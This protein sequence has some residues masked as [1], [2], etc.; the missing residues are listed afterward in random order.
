MGDECGEAVGEETEMGGDCVKVPFRRAKGISPSWACQVPTPPPNPQGTAGG[1]E[2]IERSLV[3]SR[4]NAC[5]RAS[6]V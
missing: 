4:A 5:L 3:V 1:G 2:R 6:C